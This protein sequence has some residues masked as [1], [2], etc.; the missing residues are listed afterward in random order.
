[1]SNEFA[2]SGA[3]ERLDEAELKFRMGP[4]P[5]DEGLD[6]S[7][8][9]GEAGDDVL[10][11][12]TEKTGK[13]KYR[14]QAAI[15]VYQPEEIR[16]FKR[17]VAHKVIPGDLI[18]VFRRELISLLRSAIV[19]S[20]K[21]A[22]LIAGYH[23]FIAM[24][25]EKIEGANLSEKA[26]HVLRRMREIDPSIKDHEHQNIMRWLRAD[27]QALR[28]DNERMVRP[29]AA[30]DWKRFLPFMKAVGADE[31]A[32]LTYWRGMI[33][34]TR[35]YS[36][37]EGALFHEHLAAFLVDP[38]GTISSIARGHSASDVFDAIR[39]SVEVVVSVEAKDSAA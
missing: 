27:Q 39:D 31:A 6:F 8:S 21:T 1:M 33:L 32:A 3:D 4:E 22:S 23:Q 2:T 26:F 10:V 13:I 11:I 28:Q 34:P 25:R 37:Q 24:R 12:T 38:E 16:P 29:E 17:V 35:S 30:R 18:P 9:G 19:A 36:V 14:R 7:R 15:P 5:S 20:G